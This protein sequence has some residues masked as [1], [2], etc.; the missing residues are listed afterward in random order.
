MS[1]GM[2]GRDVVAVRMLVGLVNCRTG[3]VGDLFGVRR[4]ECVV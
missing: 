1:L 4:L 3:V 2:C